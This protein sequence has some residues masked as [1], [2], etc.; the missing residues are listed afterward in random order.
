MACGAGSAFWGCNTVKQLNYE[1][2]KEKTINNN[3]V[4]MTKTLKWAKTVAGNLLQQPGVSPE[5]VWHRPQLF[6]G[7]CGWHVVRAVRFWGSGRGCSNAAA[8]RK[9]M[10]NATLFEEL[11]GGEP[12]V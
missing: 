8:C 9:F 10:G 6:W 4:V 7:I 3:S 2:R 12:T 1:R 11:F 5:S